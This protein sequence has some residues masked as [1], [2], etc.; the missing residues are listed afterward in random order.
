MTDIE[1]NRPRRSIEDF[2]SDFEDL[3]IFLQRSWAENKSQPLLYSAET[4]ASY[5]SYPGASFNLAPTLYDDSRILAF[6]AGFPRRVHYKGRTLS[7]LITA[8]LTV[9]NDYKNC[10]YGILLW[11]ALVKRARAAGYDGVLSYC[12]DGEPMNNM[13]LGCYGRMQI[14]ARKIFSA[15]YLTRFIMPK[16]SRPRS[17]DLDECSI[18]DFLDIASKAAESAS[19]GKLWTAEEAEWQCQRRGNSIVASYSAVGRSGFLIGYLMSLA[20]EERTTVLILDDVLWN[21]LTVDERQI[22]VQ[23]L[24]DRAAFAGAQMVVVPLQGYADPDPFLKSHFVHSKRVIH[25][26]LGLWN[27]GPAPEAI[28]SFYVDIF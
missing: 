13:M 19:L 25:V 28:D 1:S 18:N 22:L 20:N 7:I 14:P 9:A 12:V 6:T 15:H 23:R 4:M 27:E 24:M 21:D 11:S 10:G 8:F 3:A 26:Y 16:R 2:R 5:F 17:H